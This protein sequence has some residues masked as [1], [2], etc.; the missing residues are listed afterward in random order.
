M[1]RVLEHADFISL[2]DPADQSA[3]AFERVDKLIKPQWPDAEHPQPMHVDV[4]VDDF[5]V[6]EAGVLRLGGTRLTGGTGAFR[7][8]ADPSGHPFC[9]VRA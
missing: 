2:G 1:I 7:V 3:V 4:K 8:Y 6:G 9:Q 5:D